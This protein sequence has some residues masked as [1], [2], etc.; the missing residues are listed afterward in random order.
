V[1]QAKVAVFLD[2]IQKRAAGQGV[3]AICLKP[4][5]P[6]VADAEAALTACDRGA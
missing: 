2:A 6:L 5:S 3:N 4:L 1:P